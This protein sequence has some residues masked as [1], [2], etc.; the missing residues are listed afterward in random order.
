MGL[1]LDH[2]HVTTFWFQNWFVVGG[3]ALRKGLFFYLR[4]STLEGFT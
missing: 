1:P 2:S 4:V 3:L